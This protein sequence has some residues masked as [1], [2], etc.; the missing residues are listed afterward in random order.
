LLHDLVMDERFTP[1]TSRVELEALFERSR[2]EPV[3][4]FKHDPYCSISSFAYGELLKVDGEIPWIDVANDQP[5]SF[6]FA[7]RTGVKHES[8][9]VVILRDTRPVW[10]GSHWSIRADAIKA[11]QTSYPTAH[12]GRA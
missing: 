4:V 5:L 8:P 3:T 6:L 10:A 12:G 9:Q 2:T 1:V 7:E 11:A